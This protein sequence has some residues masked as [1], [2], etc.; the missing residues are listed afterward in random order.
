VYLF[1]RSVESWATRALTWRGHFAPCVE[2]H[3]D[4]VPFA[5]SR[6]V[7]RN[8]DVAGWKARSVS[9]RS[10]NYIWAILGSDGL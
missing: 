4:I 7:A 10:G 9:G 8:G 6:D 3:L 5:G 2:I 1:R